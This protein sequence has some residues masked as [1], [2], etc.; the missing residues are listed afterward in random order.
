[1]G[2]DGKDDYKRDGLEALGRIRDMG[3]RKAILEAL[4]FVDDLTIN[5]VSTLAEIIRDVTFLSTRTYE[6]RRIATGIVVGDREN[7]EACFIEEWFLKFKNPIPYPNMR[8]Q[9]ESISLLA[10][11]RD[12]LVAMDYSGHIYGVI[13]TANVE[14]TLGIDF[15][16]F[17]VHTNRHGETF[18]TD[19]IGEVVSF[20]DGYEWRAGIYTGEGELGPLA[21]VDHWRLDGAKLDY[22]DYQQWCA[23]MKVVTS[24]SERRLSSIFALCDERFVSHFKSKGVLNSLR[25]E[26]DGAIWSRISDN[27][28]AYGELFRLDGIHILS[29]DLRIFDVCQRINIPAGSD[30]PDSGAGRS[31]ARYLS[32]ML[33]EGGRVIKVS[34]DGPVSVFSNGKVISEWPKEHSRKTPN[35]C[36]QFDEATPRD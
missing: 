32:S 7:F 21:W 35:M 27:F 15:C 20:H 13:N 12:S 23:F 6:G 19:Y 1:M 10:N 34:S 26:L 29:R 18:L 16:G 3:T 5:S 14:Y 4:S 28:Q 22:E 33:A 31:A 30:S 8:N 11:G 2:I 24:L 36:L 17:T 9:L 25:P